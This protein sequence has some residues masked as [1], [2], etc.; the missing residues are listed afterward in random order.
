[1]L[2]V[3]INDEVARVDADG[4]AQEIISQVILPLALIAKSF[5]QDDPGSGQLF[6]DVMR[7]AIE[8]DTIMEAANMEAD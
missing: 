7:S 4:T 5:E 3:I 1:M 2:K 6:L 8:T